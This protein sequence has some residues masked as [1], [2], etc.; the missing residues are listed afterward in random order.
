M[1]SRQDSI[2]WQ[3]PST[4]EITF[5]CDVWVCRWLFYPAP[6]YA[7]AGVLI[8]E[9][10]NTFAQFG[11][12]PVLAMFEWGQVVWVPCFKCRVTLSYVCFSCAVSCHGGLV[13]DRFI[14]AVACHGEVGLGAAIAVWGLWLGWFLHNWMVVVWY[15]CF[16]AFHVTITD[17]NCVAVKDF[18]QMA[19]FWE[20]A[21]N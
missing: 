11:W 4:A 12:V 17:L 18:M 1:W 21:I 20:V 7:V 9:V 2:P 13:D 3:N 16:D 19:R 14:Q 6:G 15:Y 10:P 8:F 5:L